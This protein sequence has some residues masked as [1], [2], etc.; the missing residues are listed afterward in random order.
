MGKGK[1]LGEIWESGT[2]DGDFGFRCDD[3]T[4]GSNSASRTVFRVAILIDAVAATDALLLLCV[5]RQCPP[6]MAPL[7]VFDLARNVVT[8]RAL[9]RAGLDAL[10]K[11]RSLCPLRLP[12]H[13]SF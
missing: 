2:P 1:I 4:L 10:L 5:A 3:S 12:Y 11:P 6:E 7:K 9:Q 8:H 13:V